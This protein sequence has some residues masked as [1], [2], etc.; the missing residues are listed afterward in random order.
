[1]LFTQNPN[2]NYFKA[3]YIVG[4]SEPSNSRRTPCA[5]ALGNSGKKNYKLKEKKKT[6]YKI[7]QK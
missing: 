2:N 6:N 4:L 1:M 3:L 7:Y 5:Q